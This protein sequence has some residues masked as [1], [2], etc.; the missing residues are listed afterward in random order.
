MTPRRVL[1]TGGSKGI[2]QAVATALAERGWQVVLVAR[3]E[4]ALERA[5]A[6]LAGEGHEAIALD[7]SDEVEWERLAPQ[8]ETIAAVV[9][10][11]GIIDPIGPIGSYSAADFRRTLDVNV[12]G[13]LLAV[14]A[15]LAGLR[16]SAGSVVTFSGGGATGPLPRFDA[17]ATSKAAVVRLS[18]NLAAELAAD[19]VRV[20]AV[21]PGFVATDIHERTLAAGPELVGADYFER[22]L[23]DLERG[24]VPASDA[25]ELVCL[26]LEEADVTF[27]GKL[28]SAQW[29]PWRDRGFRARLSA[30]PDLATLRRI[31]DMFFTRANSS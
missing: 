12:V 24:G 7:V 11:A 31:D 5:R 8:L 2:G 25:A 26:L 30:E 10:A 1:V 23:R 4:Q 14:R 27:T 9:C 6:G 19:G 28:L 21:A 20:N 18:A 3:G 16:A 17:Y 13:T 29:D 15:C 22:T